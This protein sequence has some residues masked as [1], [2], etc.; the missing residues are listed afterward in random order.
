MAGIIGIQGNYNFELPEIM[1]EKIKHRGT[2]KRLINLDDN[3][4]IGI[5]ANNYNGLTLDSNHSLEYSFSDDKNSALVS[6]K[7][8]KIMLRRDKYGVV[9]F[10]YIILPNGQLAFSTEVKAL[11]GFK[12][13]INELEPGCILED[14]QVNKYYELTAEET[15]DIEPTEIGSLLRETLLR[16][17]SKKISGNKIGAWLSGGLDSSIISTIARPYIK[18]LHTF[19]AGFLNSPDLQYAKIVAD[20]LGSIHH[21]RIVAFDEVIKILPEVIYHLESFDPLL[22]RSSVMNFLAAQLASDFVQVVFSGEGGDE[23]FAGYSYLK[24]IPSEDLEEEL[25]DITKRLHNTALQ[26][27]DRC[28]GAFGTTAITPFLDEE[29]V[30]L[31]IRIPGKYKIFGETEKWILRSAFLNDLPYNVIMRPKS[32]FWEGSGMGVHL[33]GYAENIISD[34]EFSFEKN[35]KCGWELSSKEE[36]LYYRI[37]TEYFGEQDDL[38]WTG[39]T[40]KVKQ[41]T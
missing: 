1:L 39:R 22:V 29:V 7:D 9:P 11:A 24:E 27:V 8:K 6:I 38:N 35:I 13:K 36:L 19:A 33:L 41:T 14:L 21:E 23:L 25:I 15:V 3:I 30:N 28:S 17:V 2:E 26:R 32:K 10:Y 4:H 40:K 5:V 12:L 37:F 34:T 20:Y 31:A 16:V 18:D